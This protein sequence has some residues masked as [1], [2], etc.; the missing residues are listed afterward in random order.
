MY[1]V[2]IEDFLKTIF[3]QNE[4]VAVV[5]WKIDL[6][7]MDMDGITQFYYLCK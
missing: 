2:K 5:I 1:Y 6:K 3:L 4:A 7:E